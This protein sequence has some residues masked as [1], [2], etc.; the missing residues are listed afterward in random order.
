METLSKAENFYVRSLYEG[1]NIS[2]FMTPGC[3]S[4]SRAKSH[5]RILSCVSY[6]YTAVLWLG[7]LGSV[8][9][10]DFLSGAL[11]SKSKVSLEG[12]LD[13]LPSA[14]ETKGLSSSFI[15][16]II[17]GSP[18]CFMIHFSLLHT[19]LDFISFYT[20]LTS[21]AYMPLIENINL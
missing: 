5:Y 21:S 8:S 6:S 15:C 14:T 3:V 10:L 12:F 19:K 11:S 13:P 16:I 20:T 18:I 7:V 2:V 4:L 1:K 9:I 17:L